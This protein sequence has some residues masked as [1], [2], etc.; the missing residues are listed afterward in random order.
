MLKIIG[1]PNCDYIELVSP[2][3]SEM[4]ADT[5]QYSSFEIIGKYNCQ[6]EFTIKELLNQTNPCGFASKGEIYN[7]PLTFVKNS[8]YYISEI[9][10]KNVS[11]GAIL[12]KSVNINFDYYRTQCP[13]GC[14]LETLPTYETL[15]LQAYKG[16]FS[17]NG[18]DYANFNINICEDTLQTVGLPKGFT[19]NTINYSNGAFDSFDKGFSNAL[20]SITDSIIVAPQ[21]FGITRFVDGVYGFK[22]KITDKNGSTTE[23]ENCFFLDCLTK[24][25]VAASAEYI[26]ES[27]LDEYSKNLAKDLHVAHYAL[28][29]ASNC[30][31]CNCVELCEL[32]KHL[33]GIL[34]NGNTNFNNKIIETDCGCDGK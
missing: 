15:L 23:I 9:S 5:S 2:E 26:L 8:G 12:K 20:L 17:E 29:N 25:K 11:T 22:V 21:M 24:C 3:I 32:Y 30:G 18:L 10:I 7:V 4:L 33:Q 28:I 1:S 16:L 13:S 14:L 6:S 34:A 31:G 27:N 19:M